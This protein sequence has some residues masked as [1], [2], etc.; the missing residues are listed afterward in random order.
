[1]HESCRGLIVTSISQ[2]ERYTDTNNKK[3]ECGNL[4]GSYPASEK[5]ALE[6]GWMEAQL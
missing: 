2:T 3:R 4:T 5:C 1:M 6:M